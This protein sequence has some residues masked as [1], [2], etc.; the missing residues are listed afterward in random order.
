MVIQ[1]NDYER[2]EKI[3]SSDESPVGIDAKKTHIL[4]LGGVGLRP[5]REKVACLIAAILTLLGLGGCTPG[6]IK[7]VSLLRGIEVARPAAVYLQSLMAILSLIYLAIYIRTV[8]SRNRDSDGR[9]LYHRRF[10]Q[11]GSIQVPHLTCHCTTKPPQSDRLP[12]YSGYMQVDS[13]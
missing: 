4:I 10:P 2:I 1:K 13:I 8:M 9:W 6:L 12:S 11:D 5:A 7:L 3:I